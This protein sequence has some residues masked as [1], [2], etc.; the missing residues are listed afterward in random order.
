MHKSLD[1]LGYFIVALYYIGGQLLYMSVHADS[2]GKGICYTGLF[3]MSWNYIWSVNQSGRAIEFKGVMS[4]SQLKEDI[5][6]VG[7]NW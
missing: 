3:S 4:P 6:L 2:L 5:Q 1:D 7:P